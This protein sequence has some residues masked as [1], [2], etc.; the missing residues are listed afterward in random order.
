MTDNYQIRDIAVLG[1]GVMGAQI[2]AHLANAGFRPKLYDLCSD[3]GSR[4]A[5]VEKA[6]AG[7]KKLKPQP[8]GHASLAQSIVALNYDDD[9]AQLSSCDLIIE[10]VAE[11]L[12]IKQSLYEKITPHLSGKAIIASNTSGIS[13]NTLASYIPENM[14]Q[15]FCGVHFFDPPR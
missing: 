10:A 8:L 12:D 13:I 6:I 7:L 1:A 5:I 2:A 9:L 15:R 11:R 4:N 3:K 14:R